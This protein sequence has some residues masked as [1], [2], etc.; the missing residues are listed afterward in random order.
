M[1]SRPSSLLRPPP[2]PS[3]PPAVSR[4]HRL[5]AKSLPDPRRTGAEEGL[6]S[7]HD[8]HLD[9]PRP[10]RR[11]V[12][13][14]PLQVPKCLPWPSPSLIAARLPLSPGHP[15]KITT[16]QASLHAADRPVA[17][18]PL[19]RRPLNRHRG[20]RYRGPWRLPRPDSHRLA[21]TSLSPDH[22]MSSGTISFQQRRP[23]YWTHTSTFPCR[24]TVLVV[25]VLVD[26][27][28]CF[29]LAAALPHP[30]SSL[31]RRLR[32]CG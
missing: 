17:S 12:P 10:L 1:L 28:P 24:M 23:T 6:S 25:D 2:T 14:H 21:A 9:V 7:S 20:L 5:S 19:R 16:L 3:R 31:H 18:T 22:L 15:G 29:R 27:K 4:D 8:N 11:R 32:A 13:R 26:A 30:R